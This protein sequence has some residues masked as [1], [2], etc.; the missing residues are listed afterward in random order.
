[1]FWN[2][3][4]LSQNKAIKME[5]EHIVNIVYNTIEYNFIYIGH[6]KTKGMPK[7]FTEP[8]KSNNRYKYKY[9]DR[10]ET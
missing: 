5:L 9:T 7:Y 1:M 10:W 6:L 8:I 4:K 3:G 2:L